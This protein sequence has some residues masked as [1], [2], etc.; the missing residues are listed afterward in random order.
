MTEFVCPVC[1][2]EYE[3]EYENKEDAPPRSIGR[4]QHQTGICS[5]ECWDEFLPVPDGGHVPLEVGEFA[6]DRE[7]TRDDPDTVVIVNRPGTVAHEH[8]I[9]ATDR[10]VASHNTDY[11]P[12]APVVEVAYVNDMDASISRN[13]RNVAGEGF[14]ELVRQVGVSTYSFPAARLERVEDEDTGTQADS[15]NF[16]TDGGTVE[17]EFG[18]ESFGLHADPD[19]DCIHLLRHT[20]GGT[21]CLTHLNVELAEM[22]AVQLWQAKKHME[23]H[24]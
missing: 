22:W 5:D 18:L 20:D 13:W 16:M 2:R 14:A 8:R 6:T 9:P 19:N 10:T 1:G 7:Q 12:T 11:S 15:A 21:K 24:Q 17:A 4:E 3:P 23:E